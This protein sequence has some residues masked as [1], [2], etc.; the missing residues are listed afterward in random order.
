[1]RP[2]HV[3]MTLVGILLIFVLAAPSW[4]G[5]KHMK[6]CETSTQECLNK[7]SEWAKSSGWI[8]IE[9]EPQ[10]DNTWRIVKV[11]PDSPAEAG[12]LKIDDIVFAMYGIE[13]SEDN[14][15]KLKQARKDW[16]PGQEVVYTV[17]RNGHDK[18]ISLTLAPM[19]ADV[20]AQW[21]GKHMIE[22]AERGDMAQAKP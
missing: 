21:I 4:A 7:M 8:G 14:S 1:M 5:E 13:F 2:K 22:H 3:V 9:Y 20:M 17:K 10:K 11:V 19:P 12:G 16:A 18:E 6:K 15:K